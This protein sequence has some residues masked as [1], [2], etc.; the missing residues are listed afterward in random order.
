MYL[1]DNELR[2]SIIQKMKKKILKFLNM[3]EKK[4]LKNRATKR[5]QQLKRQSQKKLQETRDYGYDLNLK[6][7]H[8][9]YFPN[10]NLK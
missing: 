2:K 9:F 4:S 10:N 6:I 8:T 5:H 7:K 1:S 3:V